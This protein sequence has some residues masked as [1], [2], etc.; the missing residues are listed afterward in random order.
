MKKKI[1]FH[2]GLHK[3]ATT[4]LYKKV[5]TKV[6]KFTFIPFKDKYL[7]SAYLI[8]YNKS[9]IIGKENILG[10]AH[11][12]NY[13]KL[14]LIHK[15][16]HNAIFIISLRKPSEYVFSLY[17]FLLQMGFIYQ[18]LDGYLKEH[19]NTLE[20][21]LNYTNILFFFKKNNIQ[22]KILFYENYKKKNFLK[23]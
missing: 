17:V 18:T 4:F 16:N 10:S 12:I 3:N 8:G 7:K 21:K 1:F 22:F 15:K 11:D 23:N 5:F 9:L 13:Y 14:K 19:F 20:K 2:I 6:K